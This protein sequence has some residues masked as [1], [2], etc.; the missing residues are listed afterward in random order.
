MHASG[1]SPNI[2]VQT[3]LSAPRPLRS[4]SPDTK[5]PTDQLVKIRLQKNA[6]SGRP[7]A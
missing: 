1:I 4:T 5:M 7:M 3:M 6:I 2:R